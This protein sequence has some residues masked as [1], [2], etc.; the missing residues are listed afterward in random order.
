MSAE[1][2]VAYRRLDSVAE[3]AGGLALGRSV[4]E[5]EGV[6]VPYL[7]VANVQDGYIDTA[8]MKTV[9]VLPGEIER[10]RVRKGDLLLTEGGDLDKLGRGAVW[11]NR[12]P[13]CLHQNHLFRVRSNRDVM[14]PE[15][16]SAYVSSSLGKQYFL[17]VAKQTTNL[18]T[19]NSSQLKSMPIPCPSID[20]QRGVVAT[21]ESISEMEV[22]IE[23]AITKLR[24]VRDGIA[25]RGMA[26]IAA[27]EVPSGW[28]RVALREVVPSVDYGIS[29]VLNGDSRGIA[30]LRMN[31]LSEGR[32]ELGELRYCPQGVDS[33]RLLRVGD[34]LFNRT[35]SIEHVGKSGIW[36]GELEEATF[37]SYL[38]RLNADVARLNPRYLVEWLRHPVVR[39]RVRSIATVAVQ[40]VNVNPTRLRELLIDFPVDL[41]EQARL[42][43]SLDACDHRISVERENLAK[44]RA[45]K[46]GISDALLS[47]K[48]GKLDH[49]VKVAE[50]DVP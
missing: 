33:K 44:V 24:A 47:K 50:A 29:A 11:D 42:I 31:N 17:S 35:N 49:L 48:P 4:S 37:A 2:A 19:I 10:Y 6:E 20:A 12:I 28:G 23:T 41:Q 39:Q 5:R 16:L 46:Q 25:L 13:L 15:Y 40:Q 27:R 34:V 26:P 8:E 1:G 21:L 22:A 36:G 45:M 30:T 32:P 9:R 38:V 43:A 14:L 18:A 3:V 7:R